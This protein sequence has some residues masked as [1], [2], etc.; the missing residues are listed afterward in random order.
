MA[1]RQ[2][3]SVLHGGLQTEGPG[4]SGERPGRLLPDNLYVA[5][6]LHIAMALAFYARSCVT[7]MSSALPS[8]ATRALRER[9]K[10][11]LEDQ[12]MDFY[13]EQGGQVVIYDANNGNVSARKRCLEKFEPKGVHVIFLGA[14]TDSRRCRECGLK[15]QNPSAIGRISSLP[16]SD[17]SSY[18]HLT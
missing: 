15:I 6:P 8:E 4:W 12:I 14:L 10:N 13:F 9:I 16:T 2:D 11:E 18:H 17:P 1:R 7:L 3:T 5:L